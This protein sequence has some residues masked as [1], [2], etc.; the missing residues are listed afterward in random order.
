[1]YI[2][3]KFERKTRNRSVHIELMKINIVSIFYVNKY[4]LK[5]HFYL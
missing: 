1:M 4:Y 3:R 2:V 5:M